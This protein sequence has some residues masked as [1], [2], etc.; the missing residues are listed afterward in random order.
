MG[1]IMEGSAHR[2]V[3]AAIAVSTKRKSTLRIVPQLLFIVL[4]LI[5]G[6]TVGPDFTVPTPPDVQSLTPRPLSRRVVGTRTV[7]QF[8]LVAMFL[9]NGGSYFAPG[10]SRI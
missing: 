8:L 3:I 10:S 9:E 4:M 6:C 2:G 7:Q 1:L 5:E